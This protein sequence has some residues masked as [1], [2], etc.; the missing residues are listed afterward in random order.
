MWRLSCQGHA[1]DTHHEVEDV[2]ADVGYEQL[3]PLEPGSTG[4]GLQPCVLTTQTECKTVPGPGVVFRYGQAVRNRG[5][6][7]V[8]VDGLAWFLS[9]NSA[10]VVDDVRMV[11]EW[12][13]GGKDEVPFAPFTLDPGEEVLLLVLGHVR[14]CAAPMPEGDNM[15]ITSWRVRYH[16]LLIGQQATVRLG[17]DVLVP[18][19]PCYGDGGISRAGD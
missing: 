17:H 18:F 5:P 6:L 2:V 1:T 19:N 13:R 12:S 4:K 14:D 10:L 15:I 8:V 11:P 3:R 9:E 16:L 7:P